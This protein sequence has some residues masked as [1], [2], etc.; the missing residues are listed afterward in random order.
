[1]NILITGASGTA[2][3]SIIENLEKTRNNLILT[4]RNYSD[5]IIAGD[6]SST[7][8]VN[9]IVNDY[10]PDII[11]HLA[12]NTDV[13]FCEKNKLE[14]VLDN[15]ITTKNIV[16]SIADKNIYLI[17]TSSASIFDGENGNG[18][19]EE[20]EPH[21]SNFY[22]LTKLLSENYIQQNLSEYTILRLGWLIGVSSRSNKF[23][24]KIINQIKNGEK[25]YYGVND[26]YGS[27]T[28]SDDLA[29]FIIFLL[30][31][32]LKGIINVNSSG[33]AT[34]YEILKKIL[35][36]YDNNNNFKLYRVTNDSFNLFAKRPKYEILSNQK[37]IEINFKE[38]T[39][40]EQKLTEYLKKIK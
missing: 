32:P 7:E 30:D 5:G 25:I 16:D 9:K 38:I 20:D 22:A 29:D 19:T 1:M 31:N 37:L 12:A 28:F 4:D 8:F 2:A 27:L 10:S 14:C 18:Y 23:F 33:V 6:L 35:S 36:V 17:F 24:G 26:T 3:F 21:P 39:Y 40:W 34:R 15:F 13:D 11:I